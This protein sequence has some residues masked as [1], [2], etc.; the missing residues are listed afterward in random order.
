MQDTQIAKTMQT[1]AAQ[2]DMRSCDV[3]CMYDYVFSVYAT[4]ALREQWLAGDLQ[5]IYAAQ[6]KSD[7]RMHAQ[8]ELSRSTSSCTASHLDMRKHHL[9][10]FQ[11]HE[12]SSHLSH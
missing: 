10:A 6:N 2:Y 3:R 1:I 4:A 12:G 7:I 8:P 11:H 9:V 5:P